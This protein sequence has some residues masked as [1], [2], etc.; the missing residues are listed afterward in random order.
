MNQNIGFFIRKGSLEAN[1]QIG[2]G[3][4][5]Q[6]A[7]TWSNS[8]SAYLRLNISNM[9]DGNRKQFFF[10]NLI[11]DFNYEI[12]N[13]TIFHHFQKIKALSAYFIRKGM[14][15]NVTI[16]ASKTQKA[17]AIN[18]FL[19]FYNSTMFPN[20]TLLE[21]FLGTSFPIQLMNGSNL[22][23]LSISS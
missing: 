5:R 11:D 22:Q 13:H 19:A 20:Q 21:S 17:Q 16:D 10:K 4:V 2:L 1:E 14:S 18:P 9:D 15:K 12:A 8:L 23:K 6:I 3:I 7:H